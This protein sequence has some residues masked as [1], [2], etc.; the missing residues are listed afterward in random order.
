MDARHISGQHHFR[1]ALLSAVSLDARSHLHVY[2]CMMTWYVMPPHS[3][4]PRNLA[5][6]GY[7]WCIDAAEAYDVPVYALLEKWT[8]ISVT[9][10][11]NARQQA[12]LR[13]LNGDR[14]CRRT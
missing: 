10:L 8:C 13:A 9:V 6:N 1:S 14:A 11:L 12:R 2:S 7:R 5:H 4:R 3:P